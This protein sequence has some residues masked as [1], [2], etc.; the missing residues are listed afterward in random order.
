VR[1]PQHAEAEQRR[2]RAS[3]G[4]SASATSADAENR[5]ADRE[6]PRLPARVDETP[7]EGAATATRWANA[8]P[9]R[10]AVRVAAPEL[11][12]AQDEQ[13]PE[14]AGR[15]GRPSTCRTRARRRG[16]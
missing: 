10:A 2:D 7:D 9:A 8:P 14:R 13:Q 11:A 4:T 6:D 1:A 15:C 12:D 3:L 16:R 5:G